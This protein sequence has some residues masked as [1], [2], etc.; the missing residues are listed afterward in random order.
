MNGARSERLRFREA[1][2]TDTAFL[3]ELLNEPSWRR[4]IGDPG[5]ATPEGARRYLDERLVPLYR[6]GLGLW[7][8]ESGEREALGLC[9]L[10][11]RDFLPAVDIGFA[12]L[13]RHWRRGYA[14]EAA[15]AVLRY[16]A[17]ELARARVQAIT[18]A[19]N[20]ASV[21][22]LGALGFRFVE[23]TLEPASS[24]AVDIYERQLDDLAARPGS[25][26]RE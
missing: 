11:D 2:D 22:L 23:T 7:V 12:L 3:F 21:A 6:D 20:T 10:V 24:E 16:A 19:H 25:P 15:R 26:N 13:E 5:P 4:Y 9:G 18:R 17:G 1:D 14:R 8:I